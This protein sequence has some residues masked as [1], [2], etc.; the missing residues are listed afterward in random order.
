[1]SYVLQE[2]DDVASRLLAHKAAEFAAGEQRP[3]TPEKPKTSLKTKRPLPKKTV[4]LPKFFR[5]D[6]KARLFV[7]ILFISTLISK[8]LF[9]MLISLLQTLQPSSTFEGNLLACTEWKLPNRQGRRLQAL[10]RLTENSTDIK[11]PKNLRALVPH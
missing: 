1:M 3:A 6:P 4:Q 2:V 7:L 11:N 9:L 5:I 10:V 8:V